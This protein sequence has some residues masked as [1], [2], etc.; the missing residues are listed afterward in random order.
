MWPCLRSQRYIVIHVELVDFLRLWRQLEKQWWLSY[1]AC[2]V[3]FLMLWESTTPVYMY[4]A[5]HSC[6]PSG[7]CAIVATCVLASITNSNYVGM[8]PR[9][10]KSCLPRVYPWRHGRDKMCQA[11]PN[12]S[13]E[14]LGT[15]LLSTTTYHPPFII[16]PDSTTTHLIVPPPTIPP[17]TW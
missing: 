3:P 10:I 6:L 17:P 14:S 11:L 4:L 8:C 5:I 9:A 16:P 12:L 7:F 15:R 13:R 1:S 2:Q